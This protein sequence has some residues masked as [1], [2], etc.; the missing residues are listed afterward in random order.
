LIGTARRNS[1]NDMRKTK[2]KLIYIL[3]ILIGVLPVN[4]TLIWLRLAQSHVFTINDILVFPLLIGGANILLI[5]ILNK[6]LLKQK[7]AAFNPGKGNVGRDIMTGITLTAGYLLLMYIERAT[8]Q[9]GLSGGRPPSQEI[10]NLMTG[11]ANNSLKLFIWLGPVVWIGVAGFEE[12]QR[13]FFMNC[14]WAVSKSKAWELISIILVAAVW[15]LMH[16]YQGAFGIISV[17]VQGLIMGFYY[18]RYRRIWPLIIS[19]AL[20]DSFQVIMFVIQVR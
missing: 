11:L 6:Y 12:L 1:L 13:V 3:A 4:T 20:Y 10:I 5:L 17:S 9:Q 19:H 15:G 14:L 16:F 7:T 18:Y 2:D 8:I